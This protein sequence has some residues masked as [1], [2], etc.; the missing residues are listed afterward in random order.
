ML[1]IIADPK[2]RA[3]TR[4][5]VSCA[6]REIIVREVLLS[7]MRTITPLKG[8]V[9]VLANITQKRGSPPYL[10]VCSVMKV[11]STPILGHLLVQDV[12]RARSRIIKGLVRVHLA[13]LENS[14]VLEVHITAQVVSQGCLRRLRDRPSAPYVPRVSSQSPQH[15]QHAII[16]GLELTLKKEQ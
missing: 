13:S 4:V 16:V 6:L 14:I 5:V 11:I 12:S 2:N 1:D 9:A 7:V 15:L 10:P 3:G 8:I